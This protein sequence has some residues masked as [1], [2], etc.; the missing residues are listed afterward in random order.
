MI[1][2]HAMK[3]LRPFSS[4]SHNIDAIQTFTLAEMLPKHLQSKVVT[5]EGLRHN[6]SL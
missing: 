6:L 3:F 2:H 1:L 4:T 5:S